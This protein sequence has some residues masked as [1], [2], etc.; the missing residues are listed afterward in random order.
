MKDIYDLLNEIETEEIEMEELAVTE[1]EKNKVKKSVLEQ[2]KNDKK[3]KSKNK[4]IAAGICLAI[5]GGSLSIGVINPAYAAKIPV[6]GDIFRAI[7]DSG[8]YENFKE[9]AKEI[10]VTKESNGTAI[11][12]VDA[13]FDGQTIYYTMEIETKNILAEELFTTDS[14]VFIKDYYGGMGG[15]GQIEKAEEN[16]YIGRCDFTINEQREHIDLKINIQELSYY[17]EETRKQIKG[18]WE[19]D[20]SLDAV[21]GQEQIINQG[22]SQNGISI[23][24]ESIRKTPVSNIINYEYRMPEGMTENPVNRADIEMKVMDDLGN[25]YEIIGNSGYQNGKEDGHHMNLTIEQIK[26]EATKLYLQP[27]ICFPKGGGGVAIHE[28]GTEEEIKWEENSYKE[29]YDGMQLK[30]IEIPLK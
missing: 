15:S 20:I 22:I 17:E 16:I 26:E 25:E 24:V 9:N 19:F 18:K 30:T 28:D 12:I 8:K 4:L 13:I 2:I 7:D 1:E 5:F 6:I 21:K 11:T 27:S 23:Q 29:K 10:N 3:P 14:G